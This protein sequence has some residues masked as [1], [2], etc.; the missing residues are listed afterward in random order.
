[1]LAESLPSRE[2]RQ[3]PDAA[4]VANAG[5]RSV[6]MLSPLRERARQRLVWVVL[7]I[8]LLAIFEG[9]IRKY[10][11]PQLGQ[12][13]FFIRDPFLLYAYLLATRFSLWPRHHAFLALSF[14]MCGF[15]LL[16]F[17]MQT[18]A[19]GLDNIRVLLGIYGWRSYFFYIPLA[20]L[21]GTHFRSP[22]LLLFARV[23]L[24]LAVPIAVLVLFQFASP[25]GAPINVGVAEDKELQFKS[26]GITAERIRTTGTFTSPAGHQQFITTAFAFLLAMLLASKRRMSIVLLAVTAGGVLTCLALS[27][28]RGAVLHCGLIS[29]FAICIGFLGR[30]AAL[31]VKALILPLSLAFAAT[32]LYPIIFP[33]GF[34]TFLTRWNGAAAAESNIE[35]GVFGRAILGALDFGRLIETV[36]LLGYGLGYGGNASILLGAEVDGIKPGLLVEADFSRQM[37]DLGP[38]FGLCYVAVRIALIVWVGRRA[39]MATRRAPDPLPMLLFAYVSYT[40][41]FGQITGNGTINLY[42]WLFTGLCIAASREALASTRVPRIAMRTASQ[43]PIPPRKRLR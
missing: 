35:G 34:E 33:A 11:A 19:G 40:M 42:G 8:Y 30:S 27:G 29:M 37:V 6:A 41:F 16:L 39:W 18:A 2:L 32:V 13:I 9:A 36:P 14:F 17:A 3:R 7:L 24:M 15:G 25:P 38:V 20:F 10:I 12:Y 23:T 22:D 4:L 28:G 5:I 31:K 21:V 1:M 43:P 26:F